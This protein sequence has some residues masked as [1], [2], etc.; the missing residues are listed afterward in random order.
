MA[1]CRFIAK[2]FLPS[3][4]ILNGCAVLIPFVNPDGGGE[5]LSAKR[6]AV[7]CSMNMA[8][9]LDDV[10]SGRCVNQTAHL[11]APSMNTGGKRINT[12]IDLLRCGDSAIRT[13]AA[14]VVV[15]LWPK[16]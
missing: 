2:I 15:A 13:F 1:A 8:R 11:V 7:S 14:T 12:L 10:N 6:P 3:L 4:I 16:D 9:D 5:T